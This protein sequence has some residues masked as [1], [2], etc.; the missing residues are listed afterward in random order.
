MT[1]FFG[2]DDPDEVDNPSNPGNNTNTD[3]GDL[4]AESDAEDQA[5]SD[6]DEQ[7]GSEQHEAEVQEARDESG[8]DDPRSDED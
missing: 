1:G 3:A 8:F 2:N 4:H 5:R 7:V 6:Y